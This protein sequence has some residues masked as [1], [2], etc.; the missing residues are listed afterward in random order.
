MGAIHGI[1]YSGFIGE[2]YKKFPFPERR[3]DF[4]Q[5]PE[6]FKNQHIFE[7]LISPWATKTEITLQ[8]DKDN[9]EIAIGSYKFSL[10]SFQELL[11][12]VW[13]GGYPR[14]RDDSLPAYVEAWKTDLTL[15]ECW[16]FDKLDL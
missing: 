6:G 1:H 9:Q 3:E 5:Q 13:V 14:W 11:H 8:A 15:S 16:L 12:Y 2:T 10:A 7:Q 4:K